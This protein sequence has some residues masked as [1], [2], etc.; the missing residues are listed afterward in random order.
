MDR[1]SDTPKRRMADSKPEGLTQPVRRKP[2][3]VMPDR[4]TVS[5]QPGTRVS[6]AGR[7]LVDICV[8]FDTTGSMS[9][10]IDGL[11]SCVTGFVDRLAE[12]GLNCS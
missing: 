3:L 6:F 12:L 7:P 8:V 2:T 10:K 11:I 5:L 4:S 9:D 1:T